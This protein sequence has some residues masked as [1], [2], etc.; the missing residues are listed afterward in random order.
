MI[1]T[2]QSTD[3]RPTHAAPLVLLDRNDVLTEIRSVIDRTKVL[4]QQE[5]SWI[6]DLPGKLRASYV[7]PSSP[8][9]SYCHVLTN[10]FLH[11]SSA[12][13]TLLNTTYA[14]SPVNTSPPFAFPAEAL[15]LEDE[16]KLRG[17]DLGDVVERLEKVRTRLFVHVW[18]YDD[19]RF[20][21]QEIEMLEHGRTKRK[22][23]AFVD[24][25]GKS[26]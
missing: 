7:S 22:L 26:K 10:I 14:H 6:L 13:T 18:I 1:L 21:F 19:R 5:A 11:R 2:F 16:A 9:A 12:H 15:A 23:G 24:K 25:W 17:E 8:R 20:G 4:D 3:L